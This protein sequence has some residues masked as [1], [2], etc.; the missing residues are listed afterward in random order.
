MAPKQKSTEAGQAASAGG[1]A[2]NSNDRQA[3][4]DRGHG[5]GHSN[6]A[7]ASERNGPGAGNDRS[8]VGAAHGDKG[9]S[10]TAA[11]GVGTKRKA[12]GPLIIL[13]FAEMDVAALRRYCRLNKL[14]PKSKAQ[15]DLIA[16][17]S[18]HWNAANAKEV[19]SVAYFLYAVKHRHNVLKLTMPLPQQ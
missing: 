3:N 2:A 6:G 4:S 18:K 15:D 16:V 11:G 5:H 8:S 1:K 19:D 9:P 14:K 17:A 12:E 13:D 7:S 10:T